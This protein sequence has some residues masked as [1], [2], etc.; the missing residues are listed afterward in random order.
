MSEEVIKNELHYKECSNNI[1]T[2]TY[3]GIQIDLAPPDTNPKTKFGMSKPSMFVVPPAALL[4]LM[5]AMM[6]GGKKYGPYN[7]RTDKV[8]ASIYYDAAMRH[9]LAW[10]DGEEYSDDTNPPVH[11]LGHVMACCAILL[12]TKSTGMLNDNRPPPG[13][14]AELMKAM[15]VPI[16]K[17]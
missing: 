12:D 14:F 6:N 11:H 4:A 7:F 13:K 8:S 10:L 3:N 9:L 17:E 5:G 1:I 2:N 16:E 15:T